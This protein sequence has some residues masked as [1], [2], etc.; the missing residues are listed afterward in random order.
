[1]WL[2]IADLVTFCERK[3]MPFTT[4]EDWSSI[5][6]TTKDIQSGKVNVKNV[7]QNSAGKLNGVNG[8]TNSAF[9]GLKNWTEVGSD[10]LQYM[11]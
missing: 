10:E 4:F 5:L 9:N 1:M 8:T 6:A 2:T 7:A 11:H 3:G